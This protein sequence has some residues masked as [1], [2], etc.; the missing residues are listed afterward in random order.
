VRYGYVGHVDGSGY[1]RSN[2]TYA[3]LG[4]EDGGDGVVLVVRVFVMVEYR[5][6]GRRQ[7]TV[8]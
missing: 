1:W 6:G 3:L 2:G 8:C 5:T 4:I 7:Q